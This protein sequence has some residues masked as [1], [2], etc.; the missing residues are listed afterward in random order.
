MPK[1]WAR[2]TLKFNTEMSGSTDQN[3]VKKFIPL[4][5][6]MQWTDQDAPLRGTLMANAECKLVLGDQVLYPHVYL[7]APSLEVLLFLKKQVA[8][9]IRLERVGVQR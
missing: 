6:N 7:M 1:D 4:P 9:T 8:S 3:D 2:I 5:Q